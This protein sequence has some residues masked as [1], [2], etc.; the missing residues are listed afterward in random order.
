MMTSSEWNIF[1]FTDPLWGE[2]NGEPVDSP[3]K[4]QWRGTLMFLWSLPEQTVEQ[5]IETRWF[6]MPLSSLW[7]HCNDKSNGHEGL[8][9]AWYEIYI[10]QKY[11]QMLL[12]VRR[13]KIRYVI[14]K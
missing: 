3:L 14:I 11:E 12:T 6:E 2:S 5:T 10:L 1:C 8:I 13:P 9:K 4:G 7:R